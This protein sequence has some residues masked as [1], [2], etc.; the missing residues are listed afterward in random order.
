MS[1]ITDPVCFPR[2]MNQF[3]PARRRTAPP[4]LRLSN[5]LVAAI[6]GV[7]MLA[8]GSAL[9]GT[10][11]DGGGS[12]NNWSTAINWN[13]NATP[14]SPSALNFGGTTQLTP[15]ND[16]TNFTVKGFTFSSGAGAFVIGGN[17]IYL[18]GDITNNSTSAET[19]NLNMATTSNRTID[20][21][22]GSIALGG[23]ISGT[24]SLTK[25]GVGTSVLSGANTYSGGTT[26]DGGV[27]SV[28]T[29]A[30]GG[31]AS[32][33][34]NSGSA[35]ANLTV[36][37]GST[38]RYT[39]SS[40]TI[41]RN[42]DLSNG[43]LTFDITSSS[44]GLTFSDI[45]SSTYNASPGTIAI[46][47][48]GAGTL[49]LNTS[50]AN[51]SSLNY[52]MLSG[53]VLT[54]NKPFNLVRSGLGPA[55]FISGN[56]NLSVG[57]VTFT[58]V[59]ATI[60][61]G[62]NSGDVNTIA[63]PIVLANSGQGAGVPTGVTLMITGKISGGHAFTKTDAGI[64]TLSGANTYSGG[65]TLD[66]GVLSVSTL[67]NGGQASG[68]G[69]SGSAAANLTVSSGSTLRYTGSSVTINRNFD[70]S[71]GILTFDITSSSAGLTFSDINSS[72]YNASPGTIAIKKMGA[73]T[74]TLNTSVA[75]TSSLNYIMLSGGVLTGN[76]PFNLVR[77]QEALFIS[78]NSTLSL[79]TL[80]FTGANGT[81]SVTGNSGNVNT[82]A[83]PI[84]LAA[85]GQGADVPAGVTLAITGPI[86]GGQAF[87][88]T[89][90]GTLTLAGAN[91]YTGATSV[92]GGTLKLSG[93]LPTFATVNLAADAILDLNG[94]SRTFGSVG[95]AG[96]V[97]N[98]AVTVSG[99][100]RPS[101]NSVSTTTLGSLVLPENS[102]IQWGYTGTESD[103]I[104]VTQNLTLPTNAT[105][106]AI[107]VSG[108]RTNLAVLID[109]SGG[110]LSGAT[111]LSSWI[112]TGGFRV[113]LD[114]PNERVILMPKEGPLYLIR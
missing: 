59:G 50:V 74:L 12:D 47:K 113:Q 28:S 15:N 88:K 37:S 41:N 80:T 54:G 93:T 75:N 70:L 1:K 67:A 14:T 51:T 32:G 23:V 16:F 82:I 44:A 64:L 25:S 42:F 43:I 84:V 107:C 29:L 35:A 101:T 83:S 60:S 111:D 73:G 10:T 36:I 96:S 104:R 62:G 5:G 69:N 4:V 38:L 79:G 40:V 27:L 58:G 102:V 48:M 85:T 30:N 6:L 63:S 45:N 99:I 9:A 71:N 90:N 24:A 52:I 17:A 39:G 100:T 105:V 86:S 81:I 31:Q 78:G 106:N 91:T 108:T 8:A 110:T 33:I 26:L 95:G 55:L 98:G 61:A 11:W 68:I 20:V 53:G 56:S 19:I 65:T 2:I 72:T 7:L 3:S 89:G 18:A 66:G 77:V 109:Y 22:S 112:T 57:T 103:L 87:T 76:K 49:T 21:A 92:N 34:G 94:T 46:K 13:D 97:A 114:A